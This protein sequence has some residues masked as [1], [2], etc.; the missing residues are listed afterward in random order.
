MDWMDEFLDNDERRNRRLDRCA[1]QIKE[2]RPRIWNALY[3][4]LSKK[5][6]RLQ[7]SRPGLVD[8]GGLVGHQ[9]TWSIKR[10]ERPPYEV[11]VCL[12]EFAILI[13]HDFKTS[14]LVSSGDIRTT[15]VDFYC[16]RELQV[17]L[18]IG[19]KRTDIPRIVRL[20]LEPIVS[21]N[22]SVMTP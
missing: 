8:P 18:Q 15:A 12:Q 22:R 10:L 21:G 14:P 3:E 11:S 16:D 17:Y 13:E 20:I 6:K 9:D 5:V 4:G 2:Q 1:E 7:D 19:G